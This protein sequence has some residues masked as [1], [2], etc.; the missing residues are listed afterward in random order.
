M[1]HYKIKLKFYKKQKR[2]IKKLQ[3]LLKNNLKL[4]SKNLIKFKNQFKAI[5]TWENKQKITSQIFNQQQ[6]K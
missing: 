2:T 1:I 4:S 6:N 5:L 3:K